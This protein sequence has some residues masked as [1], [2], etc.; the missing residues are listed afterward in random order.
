MWGRWHEM[1]Q[2]VRGKW[3]NVP[4]QNVTSM[5]Q[6]DKDKCNAR[7]YHHFHWDWHWFGFLFEIMQTAT[8]TIVE[9]INTYVICSFLTNPKIIFTNPL[10]AF[11]KPKTAV[12]G[13][14]RE[15]WESRGLP[16]EKGRLLFPWI[17]RWSWILL[18][19][20]SVKVD[21]TI[22][23]KYRNLVEP[24]M[25]ANVKTYTHWITTLKWNVATERGPMDQCTVHYK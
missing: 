23:A 4:W 11:N 6:N 3:G 10:G 17:I 25:Q 21:G 9:H 15:S 12:H 19:R 22:D 2:V 16:T 24:D 7:T 1:Y 13:T 14:S 5:T 18:I 8:N 20:T